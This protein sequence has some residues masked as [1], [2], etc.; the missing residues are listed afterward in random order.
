MESSSTRHPMA[1]ADSITN[2]MLSCKDS[3]LCAADIEAE[4]LVRAL[5]STVL[6]TDRLMSLLCVCVCVCVC[7]FGCRE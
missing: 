5:K 3:A 6:R 7:D 4:I 1:R 2:V